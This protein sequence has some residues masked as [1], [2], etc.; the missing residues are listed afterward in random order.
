V[1]CSKSEN[2][3]LLEKQTQVHAEETRGAGMEVAQNYTK[4]PE[5]P[6]VTLLAVCARSMPYCF[7]KLEMF[8]MFGLNNLLAFG[9]F[10]DFH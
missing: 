3:Y 10:S 8:M 4:K 2:F 6:P 1:T 9:K 5:M 7:R